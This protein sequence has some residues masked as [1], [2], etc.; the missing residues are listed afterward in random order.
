MLM[1]GLDLPPQV[2]RTQIAS[3]VDMIVHLARYADG[4]RRIASIVDVQDSPSGD[5]QL[6]ELFRFEVRGFRPDGVLEGDLRYTGAR[7]T[8]LQKFHLNNVQVPAWVTT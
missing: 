4:S 1:S 3:A 5:V 7:P 2:C 6:V 8:F